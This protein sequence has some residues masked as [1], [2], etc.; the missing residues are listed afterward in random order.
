MKNS[1]KSITVERLETNEVKEF[2]AEKEGTTERCPVIAQVGNQYKDTWDAL[3][4]IILVITCTLTPINIA[5]S[6]TE[7]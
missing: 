6:Y 3:I 4:S 7:S 5:F 1:Q 2:D